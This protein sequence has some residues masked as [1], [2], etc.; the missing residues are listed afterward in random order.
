[1]NKFTR[2]LRR[3]EVLGTAGL[4]VGVCWLL[5]EVSSV[6]LPIFDA[7]EWI[8]RAIV[9]ITIVGFPIML[10][11]AWVYNVTDHGIEV[12]ADATDTVVAPLGSRKMDVVV[13]GVLSVA[14][15]LS[16]YINFTGEPEIVE[17]PEPLSVLIADF[18]NQTGEPLFEGSLEQAMN[19]G[20]EGASFITA[21]DRVSAKNLVEKLNPGSPLYADGARLVAVLEGI[22]IVIFGS[23]AEDE[24]KYKLAVSALRPEDGELISRSSVTVNKKLDV[25]GA[26]SQLTEDLRQ[27]LGDTSTGGEGSVPGEMFTATSLEALQNYTLAQELAISAN[28]EEALPYYEAAVSA[29][30][31]SGRALS[32][33]ALSLFYLGRQEKATRLWEQALSKMGSMTARER[34]R[35]LGLY[36]IAVTGNYQKAIEVYSALV[37]QYPAD[38]A[39]YSNLAIAYFSTLDFEKARDAGSRALGIYPTNKNMLSNYALYSMYA[40]DFIAAGQQAKALLEIDRNN[41]MAWLPIAMSAAASGEVEKAIQHYDAMSEIDARGAALA[42]LGRADLA[43]FSGRFAESA[44]LVTSGIG[45][46]EDGVGDHVL[47]ASYLILAKSRQMLGDVEGSR[48]SL[49]ASLAI[50]PDLST[51]VAAALINIE[52]GDIDAA[53]SFSAQLSENSQ[54]H[55]HA[56]GWLIEGVIALAEGNNVTA[57]NALRS[58]VELADLWLIRFYL[59]RAYLQAGF[60]AEAMDELMLCQERQGE[61]SA[62]FLNDL[63]TWRYMATLPYWLG[64]AQQELDMGDAARENYQR[65][66]NA[67]TAEEPLT[68]DASDRLP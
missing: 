55:A 38:S 48:A 68:Q 37:E 39:G 27:D 35:T 19:I 36:Y 33:W 9:I 62:L 40:G 14:L 64:R 50:A 45:Q 60:F 57:V 26:V 8:M 10:V 34:Y 15:L 29:N 63:P 67:Y 47:A 6:L 31:D 53:K 23:I 32:G 51:Q 43:Q 1:M 52:S 24:G 46:Q 61:A 18:D 3:R 41:Y 5:I 11:L 44:R 56:Y 30:P 2:E 22:E 20:I 58:G 54:S 21:Y 17:Q 28:Y 4:Y 65:F 66:L 7:A 42:R 59:G 13:I 16:V 12:Q 25:L 49:A